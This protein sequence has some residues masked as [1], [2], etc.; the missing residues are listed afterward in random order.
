MA[1][2]NMEF[3][4]SAPSRFTGLTPAVAG[5]RRTSHIFIAPTKGTFTR[6]GIYAV[7]EPIKR[8]PK[9]PKAKDY[10]I[11]YKAYLE[12]REENGALRHEGQQLRDELLQTKSKL[13]VLSQENEE[14]K[15]QISQLPFPENWG[16][17]I[18]GK[19]E[20]LKRLKESIHKM[21]YDRAEAINN[22]SV[23]ELAVDELKLKLR[24]KVKEVKDAKELEK[25]Q[26]KAKILN[27]TEKLRNERN[28][29]VA[30]LTRLE[31]V[32]DKLRQEAGHEKRISEERKMVI[33][34]IHK[35]LT[36]KEKHV[37]DLRK[38]L[39]LSRLFSK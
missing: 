3:R 36:S 5:S 37:D 12:I 18:R 32:V 23:A 1:F 21:S 30:N 35:R 13:L 26:S 4:V 33:Q 31:V 9:R 10:E 24:N 17:V 8:A 2:A 27:E 11:I 39:A 25:V 20:E 14:L 19:D 34:E 6:N 28:I 29:A 16:Q 15:A 7:E 38:Q 22:K